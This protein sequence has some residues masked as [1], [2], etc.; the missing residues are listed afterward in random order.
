MHE[1]TRSTSGGND[2]T[3]DEIG[4][5]L[6]HALAEGHLPSHVL[7]Q[8]MEGHSQFVSIENAGVENVRFVQFE[9]LLLLVHGGVARASADERLDAR[10]RVMFALFA[11]KRSRETKLDRTA[12]QRRGVRGMTTP[13]EGIGGGRGGPKG[14]FVGFD[15]PV[16]IVL[17]MTMSNETRAIQEGFRTLGTGMS[18]RGR[19]FATPVII[20]R[21]VNSHFALL[22]ARLVLGGD[23]SLV[24]VL[25][26][27]LIDASGT[28]QHLLKDSFMLIV[29]AFVVIVVVVAV[30]FLFVRRGMKAFH[31]HFRFVV[32][33]PRQRQSH[34]EVIGVEEGHEGGGDRHVVLLLDVD[35]H[36]LFRLVA[37]ENR[38]VDPGIALV[39]HTGRRVAVPTVD[40]PLI[41]VIGAAGE[42]RRG[43]A[44]DL[45]LDVVGLGQGDHRIGVHQPIDDL[46]QQGLGILR[47]DVMQNEGLGR[48]RAFVGEKRTVHGHA[49]RRAENGFRRFGLQ[50]QLGVVG[51]GLADDPVRSEQF[52]L[53]VRQGFDRSLR[54][55]V[56]VSRSNE[57]LEL[58][59]D[60]FE[61]REEEVLVRAIALLQVT[62]GLVAKGEEK[63]V[64]GAEKGEMFQLTEPSAL[65]HVVL[66]LSHHVLR[67][68]RAGGSRQ[69][70]DQTGAKQFLAEGKKG[71]G[72]PAAGL[73]HFGL[74][75][76]KVEGQRGVDQGDHAFLDR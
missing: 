74:L 32:E 4:V 46:V 41:D 40:V 76:R 1:D 30:R 6:R 50:H 62:F 22:V 73:R 9:L 52:F 37:G 70:A 63:G 27:G 58:R 68:L 47:E 14:D 35:L 23:A 7:G 3:A 66:D 49:D 25:V 69:D 15:L 48:S 12:A 10:T 44:A 38:L 13:T 64:R 43:F 51:R 45:P 8:L 53:R 65:G 36:V 56:Q 28:L 39:K 54:D 11:K 20:G 75:T 5:Q 61:E 71:R 2:Q 24:N 72:T 19:S 21:G 57:V 31:E 26:T 16:L 17:T 59:V 60:P 34:V 18:H 29:I 67:R 42:K 33:T 55:T